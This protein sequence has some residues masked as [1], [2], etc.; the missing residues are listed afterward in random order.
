MKKLLVIA[1]LVISTIANSQEH[2][3]IKGVEING[4]FDNFVYELSTHGCSY[5]TN[6]HGFF[7]IKGEF[8]GEEMFFFPQVSSSG[9]VYSVVV[10]SSSYKER[11]A[12]N[13]RYRELYQLLSQKYGNSKRTRIENG[14]YRN[15]YG[16]LVDGKASK[17]EVFESV[18]GLIYLYLYKS[19]YPSIEAG[20]VNM[21]Y[22]DKAN[23]QL[24]LREANSDI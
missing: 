5:G 12:L 15:L 22:I 19:D 21:I 7:M 3:K 4:S 17:A 1:L 23:E 20:Q 13:A 8:A 16:P 11:S 2:L 18:N 10:C 24:K 6:M 14:Y 9:N